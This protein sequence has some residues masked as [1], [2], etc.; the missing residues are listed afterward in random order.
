MHSKCKRSSQ[1]SRFM[2][3]S[4]LKSQIS[5]IKSSCLA[6]GQITPKL[7]ETFFSGLFRT[8]AHVKKNEA[9]IFEKMHFL[10]HPNLHI[11]L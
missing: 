4:I 7:A 3:F 6:G 5:Y 11:P 1:F 9:R 2:K 10:E 8:F